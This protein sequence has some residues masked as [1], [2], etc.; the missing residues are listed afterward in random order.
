MSVDRRTLDLNEKHAALLLEHLI[1]CG[2]PVRG[3]VERGMLTMNIAQTIDIC[4]SEA[5]ND[6]CN[7]EIRLK[8]GNT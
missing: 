2:L 7:A 1:Q 8:Y 6:R 5:L 3:E 4:V